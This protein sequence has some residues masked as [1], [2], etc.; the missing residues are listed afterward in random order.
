MRLDMILT[1]YILPAL[2]SLC[3]RGIVSAP[4]ALW[5]IHKITCHLK[6]W[7]CWPGLLQCPCSGAV[8]LFVLCWIH[9]CTAQAPQASVTLRLTAGI[10]AWSTLM[11]HLI[12]QHFSS[13][14]LWYKASESLNSA[15]RVPR[16]G[17]KP[18][19]GN[20]HSLA[21]WKCWLAERYWALA[22]NLK[23][24]AC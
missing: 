11:E 13:S 14:S 7:L 16:G 20:D 15:L 3:P 5:P 8:C 24:L 12:P 9:A 19:T 2:A 21:A 10:P 23:L 1:G 4:L 22:V 18:H 17:R 6:G